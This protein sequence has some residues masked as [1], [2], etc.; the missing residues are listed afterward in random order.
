MRNPF[1]KREPEDYLVM[2]LDDLLDS[3][4]KSIVVLVNDV[5]EL[6]EDI[7][8]LTDFVEDRID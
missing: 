5:E 1:K 2:E 8:Y 4:L 6:K 7:D 3:I